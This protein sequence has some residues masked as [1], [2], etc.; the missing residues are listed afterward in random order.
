M[1]AHLQV[2]LVHRQE[3]VGEEVEVAGHA[4]HHAPLHRAKERAV[5]GG[6]DDGELG[7]AS[8]DELA[9]AVEDRRALLGLHR[10][11]AGEGVTGRG[12]RGVG[13]LL[14]A[15]GDH[16]ERLQIDR[17]EVEEHV[18]RGDPGPTDPVVGR[19]PDALDR[20]HV[21]HAV[22]RYPKN[23]TSWGSTR[24]RKATLIHCRSSTCLS[25]FLAWGMSCSAKNAC[26]SS[27]CSGVVRSR[28]PS[29][30]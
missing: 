28:T 14:P 29:A 25:I 3:L 24:R 1:L 20:R 7:H 21:R 2:G 30:R 12:D 19:D 22:P 15:P 27:C 5:V 13:F 23:A 10:R 17:R 18:G 8:L 6:L 16:G 26:A 4:G 9:D 11:P